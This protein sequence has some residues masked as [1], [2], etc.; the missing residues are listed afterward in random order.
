MRVSRCAC[1]RCVNSFILYLDFDLD[2]S[3]FCTVYMNEL[4]LEISSHDG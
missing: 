1:V 2:P 3:A 4:S